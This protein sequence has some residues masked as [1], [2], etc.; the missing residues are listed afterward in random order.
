[1]LLS[2]LAVFNLPQESAIL[3]DIQEKTNEFLDRELERLD[4]WSK[5]LK[6]KL[7]IELRELDIE[8]TQLQ[9]DARLVRQIAEKLE[10]NKKIRQCEKNLSEFAAQPIRCTR[11]N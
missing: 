3:W 10:M 2:K 9:K 11:R 6:D 8:F 5:D 7:E 4:K 1:M